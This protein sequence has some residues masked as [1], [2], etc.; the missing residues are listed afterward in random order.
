MSKNR[1]PHKGAI[2]ECQNCGTEVR[3]VFTVEVDDEEIEVCETCKEELTDV[4]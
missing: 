2:L 1:Y 3:E 4:E